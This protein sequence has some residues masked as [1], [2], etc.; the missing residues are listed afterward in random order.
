MRTT[1]N[2]AF[3][4]LLLIAGLTMSHHGQAQTPTNL[5]QKIATSKAKWLELKKKWGNSYTYVLKFTSGEGAFSTLTTVQVKNGKVIKAST[6]TTTFSKNSTTTTKTLNAQELK[7]LKTLDEVYAF[8]EKD[9]VKR[10]P[11]QNHITFRLFANGLMSAVGYFPKNCA[12]D[13]FEGFKFD[14]IS[15]SK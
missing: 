9:L 3:F 2:T 4:A 14:K 7:R 15:P 13:C 1:F 6:S 5:A 12:D 11:K 10:S 8:A